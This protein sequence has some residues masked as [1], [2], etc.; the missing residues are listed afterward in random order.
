MNLKI[1]I[2]KTKKFTF[3]KKIKEMIVKFTEI[4]NKKSRK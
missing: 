3:D 2:L 1:T 4:V